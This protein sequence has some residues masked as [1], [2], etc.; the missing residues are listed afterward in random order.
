MGLPPG[1]WFLNSKQRKLLLKALEE[2]FGISELPG[3]VFIQNGKDK[4]YVINRDV[5]RVPFDRM[6]VDTL[7]LYMGAWQ[8]D[9][10]RLSMEGAQL[11]AP[12]ASKNVVEVDDAQ[13]Q[14]W[15]KGEDLPSDEEGSRFVIIRH[16]RTADVLGCG[17][18][19]PPREGSNDS[20][21]V[22]LNFVPKARR[23]IVVNE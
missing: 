8:V 23:L 4:V 5:E 9:G 15:L 7:G 21:A 20:S 14:S 17:K 11:L 1:N 22:I 16:A 3:L 19:R 12:L 6:Y 10:F 13:R 18:L 2:Q